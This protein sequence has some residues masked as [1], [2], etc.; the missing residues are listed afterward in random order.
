MSPEPCSICPRAARCSPRCTAARWARSFRETRSHCLRRRSRA[1]PWPAARPPPCARCPR[2]STR[3]R[4]G[5][6]SRRRGCDRGASGPGPRATPGERPPHTRPLECAPST[7]FAARDPPSHNL[8]QQVARVC[9]KGRGI[10]KQ[11]VL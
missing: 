4:W 2:P 8:T 1:C 5:C 11:D 3:R 10:T 9:V 7:L 6:P